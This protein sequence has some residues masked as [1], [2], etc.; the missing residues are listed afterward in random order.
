MNIDVLRE[1]ISLPL[2][3]AGDQLVVHR[4]GAYNMSQWQQFITLRPN[5]VLLDLQGQ[6]HV[7][8]EA[9]TL[10][11]VQQLEYVPGHLKR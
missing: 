10:A 6:P 1:S 3:A 2:L 8:R 9:E 5:V 7:I 4:V 11:Y